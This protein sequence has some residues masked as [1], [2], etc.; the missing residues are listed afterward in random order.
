MISIFCR[1]AILALC[2]LSLPLSTIAAPPTLVPHDDNPPWPQPPQ[3]IQTDNS[4]APKTPQSGTQPSK[5]L[6]ETDLRVNP[7]LTEH[8]IN[9]AILS[10][11][12]DLLADLLDLYHTMPN[13]D[14]VLYD[15]G[16]GAL[17]RG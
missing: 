14:T 13:H 6:T 8:L 4:I 5:H 16:K 12:W 3:P 9:Q 1:P 7:A 2:L 10:H 15:Y 11:Q 17:L